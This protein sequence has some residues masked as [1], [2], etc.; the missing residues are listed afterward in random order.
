MQSVT[1]SRFILNLRLRADSSA[2]GSFPTISEG[3]LGSEI[4]FQRLSLL[5]NIG[6]PL[7]IDGE[8]ERELDLHTEEVEDGL[9]ASGSILAGG[10][11]ESGD[12]HAVRRSDS[13]EL[14]RNIG[15][16]TDEEALLGNGSGSDET[17]GTKS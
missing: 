4:R 11:Q 6:A 14:K 2:V 13:L 7:D 9:W 17:Y 5:G 8:N 12:Y 1:T 16:S 3:E 10:S 15:D